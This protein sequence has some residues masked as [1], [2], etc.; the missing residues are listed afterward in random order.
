MQLNKKKHPW[1]EHSDAVYFIAV[2]DGRDVGRIA[3]LEN[4]PFNQY[5]NKKQLQFY[6]FECENDQEVANALF[7]AVFDWGRKRGL[8]HICGPKGFGP[9]DGYGILI[10]GYEHRQMMDMMNYNY[11]YYVTLLECLGFVKEVDFV[12]CYLHREKFNL[13]ERIH[14]IVKR[15]EEKGNYGVVR[16]TTRKSL[17]AWA[18][19]IGKSYNETFVHNWE[20]YPLSKREIDYVVGQLLNYADP[21]LIKI[22]T[23]GEDVIGFVFGFP[24]VTKAFKRAKGKFNLFTMLGFLT[25][26]KKTDW[27]CLNGAGVLPE[28]QG[29]GG[30]ALLYSEVEKEIKEYNFVHAELTQVAETTKQ[31]RADLV[32]LGG[33]PYK[34]H[35]VYRRN[36]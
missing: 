32:N 10:E 5:H 36:I 34:N 27:L 30:N 33:E 19:K 7:E 3:A 20:Y 29:T 11:P 4:K 18:N 21:R 22:I 23:H 24:D 14:K 6:L 8:D 2:K 35:R 28:F 15:V 17:L 9:M 31:M 1:H 25:E 12:S 16:F 13:P 26:A